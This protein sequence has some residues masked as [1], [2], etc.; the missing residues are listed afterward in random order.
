MDNVIDLQKLWKL[1]RQHWLLLM[2]LAVVGAGV[3]FSI[4]KFVIK[5][6]YAATVSILVNRADN[7]ANAGLQAAAQQADVQLI[8][9]YKNIITQPIILDTVAKNLSSTQKIMVTPARKAEYDTNRFG[10]QYLVKAGKDATYRYQPAKYDLK[11]HDLDKKISISNDPNSQV[12]NV[13]V[14][15][16]DAQQAADIANEVASVFKQKIGKLMSVKNVNVVSK[17]TTNHTPVAPNVKLITIAGLLLG[18]IIGLAIIIIRDLTDRTVKTFDFFTDDMGVNDLGTMYLVH[19]VKSYHEYR[20]EQ[21][22]EDNNEPR[23][24]QRRRV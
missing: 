23:R 19:D 10:E 9:T 17:A 8:N 2:I 18:I 24:E 6:Q 16:T 15:T 4:S 3:S 22:K 21:R 5:K 14:K 1:I 11:L 12:F 13:T 7:E 20:K